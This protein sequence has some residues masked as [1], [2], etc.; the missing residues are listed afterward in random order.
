MRAR[1]QSARPVFC[2]EKSAYQIWLASL[3][4]ER[5][6]QAEAGGGGCLFA[7]KKKVNKYKK[8]S[9][10]HLLLRIVLSPV[11]GCW[12]FLFVIFVPLFPAAHGGLSR[13][14]S[15]PLPPKQLTSPRSN[16]SC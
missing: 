9:E 6:P 7:F 13:R 16:T 11:S 4:E 1:V 15:L 14:L 10:V 12:L 3:E 5:E 2:L 8:N